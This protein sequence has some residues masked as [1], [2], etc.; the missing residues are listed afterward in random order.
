LVGSHQA[1]QLGIDACER[2]EQQRTALERNCAWIAEVRRL[3]FASSCPKPFRDE[4]AGLLGRI[5][6]ALSCARMLG[7]VVHGDCRPTH[8]S[9]IGYGKRRDQKAKRLIRA[10]RRRE[11]GGSLSRDSMQLVPAAQG[12]KWNCI[13]CVRRGGEINFHRGC[14]LTRF[15]SAQDL[16][17]IAP[18]GKTCRFRGDRIPRHISRPPHRCEFRTDLIP[19]STVGLRFG[20][21]KTGEARCV[22][23]DDTFV[24]DLQINGALGRD[25]V[26]QGHNSF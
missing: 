18:L 10:L 4:W 17:Q 2:R 9:I 12:N 3:S 25:C 26:R 21:A 8:N 5:C 16:E 6:I 15:P 1:C 7:Q 24:S 22:G 13:S 20:R 19:V 14:G 11:L 23:H